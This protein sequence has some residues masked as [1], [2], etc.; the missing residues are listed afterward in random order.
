MSQC[1]SFGRTEEPFGR[2]GMLSSRGDACSRTHPG[3][4]PLALSCRI[5]AQRAEGEMKFEVG[6]RLIPSDQAVGVE[7]LRNQEHAL[8]T[9]SNVVIVSLSMQADRRVSA[10]TPPRPDA[11]RTAS[12]TS[13]ANATMPPGVVLR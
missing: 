3:P 13:P 5:Q 10:P 1:A 6:G 7:R 12:S 8:A 9:Q 11:R 4:L 2:K